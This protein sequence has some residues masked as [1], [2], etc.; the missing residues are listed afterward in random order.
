MFASDNSL[1]KVLLTPTSLNGEPLQHAR[2]AEVMPEVLEE[3][4]HAEYPSN[5]NSLGGLQ[6][7]SAGS[8]G[9]LRRRSSKRISGGAGGGGDTT[10]GRSTSRP[11][12]HPSPSGLY[13]A[14]VWSESMVYVI[15]KMNLAFASGAVAEEGEHNVEAENQEFS[16]ESG[17]AFAPRRPVGRTPMSEVCRGL[18]LEFAWVG[19]DDCFL[20]KT[21]GEICST[22]GAG[23]AGS[24]GGAKGAGRRGSIATLVFGAQKDTSV[25]TPPQLVLKQCVQDRSSNSSTAT[26]TTGSGSSSSS[27]VIE[28]SLYLP[29]AAASCSW[30]TPAIVPGGLETPIISPSLVVSMFGGSVLALNTLGP[31]ETEAMLSAAALSKRQ[32]EAAAAALAAEHRRPGPAG[33]PPGAAAVEVQLVPDEDATRVIDDVD[34]VLREAKARQ[35]PVHAKQVSCFYTLV[36]CRWL[37]ARAAEEAS[38]AAM[39]LASKEKGKK[40]RRQ[41]TMPSDAA[42]AA[43]AATAGAA[44]E[45]DKPH[46]GGSDSSM[47][48]VAVAPMMQCVDLVRWDYE[49]GLCAVV[50]SG[51]AAVNILRL[52]VD[53]TAPVGVPGSDDVLAS[54]K[55]HLQALCSVDWSA[56]NYLSRTLCGLKWSGG[57]LFASSFS[58]SSVKII[59]CHLPRASSSGGGDAIAALPM[60]VL[61]A[62]PSFGSFGATGAGATVSN[63]T[64]TG[65]ETTLAVPTPYFVD[66]FDLGLVSA[67]RCHTVYSVHV[68]LFLF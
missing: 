52:C 8:G 15:Y 34:A 39:A 36:S 32:A 46:G 22:S 66:V 27:K 10:T 31:K 45:K 64:G 20:V 30:K 51:S 60:D 1:Q 7:P 68:I 33:P 26:T 12:F 35:M 14:I 67:V 57:L 49:R 53:P 25:Y 23:G 16:A 6:Q 50:L 38:A 17:E 37:R 42:A 61:V 2:T 44:D 4:A 56:P 62:S 59:H 24:G 28:H 55:L 58:H 11:Q 21:P 3:I 48:L 43:A 29:P 13:C 54:T 47:Q 18:C 40:G 19:S 41:S 9:M 5:S 63:I 65:G